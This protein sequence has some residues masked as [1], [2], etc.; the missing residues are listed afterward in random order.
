MPGDQGNWV[1]E[2]P[3][4]DIKYFINVCR[5]LNKVPVG[6]GCAPFAAVCR[7]RLEHS[8]VNCTLYS[9][10]CVKQPFSKRLKIGFKDQLLLNAGQKYC[11]MLQREHSAILLTFIKLPFEQG[12]VI[13]NNVAF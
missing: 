13:S 6:R 7:T 8:Q 2:G 5:S 11:R 3:G 4:S 10:T 12:H 9:E 1:V